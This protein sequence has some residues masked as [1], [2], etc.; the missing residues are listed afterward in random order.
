[1]D[2]L[3][4]FNIVFSSL[5]AGMHDFQFQVTKAFFKHFDYEGIN[6]ANIAVDVA[7]NK[8]ENFLEFELKSSGMV[9]CECDRCLSP[10]NVDSAGKLSFLV[11]FGDEEYGEDSDEYVLLPVNEFQI[12]IAQQIY[13]CICLCLPIR[14]AHEDGECD[15]KI[16]DFLEDNDDNDDDNTDPR[17]DALKSINMN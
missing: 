10:V 16:V 13:E 6:E 15:R 3:K 12:N 14:K 9:S 1:M 4:E 2:I 11:K 8:H 7:L 5:N 17:W